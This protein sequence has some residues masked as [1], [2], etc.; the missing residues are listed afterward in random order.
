M[1]MPTKIMSTAGQIP[2]AGFSAAA[3]KVM[4]SV[5]N[6]YTSNEVKAQS[7]TFQ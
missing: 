3:Q 6:I 2:A 7:S 5:V 4:P 1:K